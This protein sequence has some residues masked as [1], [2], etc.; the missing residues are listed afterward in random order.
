MINTNAKNKKLKKG[1]F[2]CLAI[3]IVILLLFTSYRM[4]SQGE[5][6]NYVS[7]TVSNET[8]R[9]YYT[10]SGNVASSNTQNVMAQKILQISE[11]KVSEGDKVSADDVLFVTTDGSEVKS[12]IDGTVNNIY[13]ETDQQ[14]VSGAKLCEIID[15]ETLEVSIKVD[16]YDLF[17]VEIGKS[18]DVRIGAID[19]G[20]NGTVSDISNTAIS[21]NG[22]SY[23][24]A[25]VDLDYDE[26]IKVGMTAEAKI[27]KEESIDT[28]IIPMKALSFDD[29][30]NPFVYIEGENNSMTKISVVPGITDGIN[31]EITSGLENGQTIYYRNTIE[32]DDNGN[33]TPLR[34]SM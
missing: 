11:I 33:F 24:I 31:V 17:S 26:D 4:T 6:N 20:I 1:L 28:T 19:K 22:V 25:T 8:I 21:Q 2:I 16:E 32:S 34:D 23:F 15:F 10:F 29:E 18:I 14:V 13:V 12:K 27:L 5:N 3:I 7:A 9:K 30:N